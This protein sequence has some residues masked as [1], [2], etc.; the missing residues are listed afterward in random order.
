M[1]VCVCMCMFVVNEKELCIY[2][3]VC[4]YVCMY[5]MY[6]MYVCNVCMYVCVYVCQAKL[7]YIKVPSSPVSLV[8]LPA[9]YVPSFDD[10][11]HF[12]PFSAPRNKHMRVATPN[13]CVYGSACVGKCV[14]VCVCV[15]VEV[16]VWKYVFGNVCVWKCVCVYGSVYGSV[17]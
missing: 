7:H 17:C 1:C 9:S 6:V 3:Y 4:M 5:V 10:L 8:S 15:C 11:K 2:M 12:R 13:K 16:R 14:F